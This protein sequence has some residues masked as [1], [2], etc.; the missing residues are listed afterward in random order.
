MAEG[1]QWIDPAGTATAL[2]DPASIFTEAGATGRLGVAITHTLDPLAGQPGALLRY[3]RVEPRKVGLPLVVRGATASEARARV[4]AL[5]YA[6]DPTRGIGRLRAT[7]PDGAQRELYAVYQDGLD[8]AE[9]T[10]P[11]VYRI[12]LTLIAPDPYWYAVDATQALYTLSGFITPL[13]HTPFFPLAIGGSTIN[14]TPT[15]LNP[16]DVDAWPVWIISGPGSSIALQNLTTGQS[17]LLSYSLSASDTVTIDTRPD[18]KSVTNSAGANLYRYLTA[19]SVL[20]ALVPGNNALRLSLAEA[21]TQ[22]T[23]RLTYTP[24]WIAP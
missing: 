12:P 1:L 2:D 7:A 24:R 8:Q 9:E 19:G 3:S 5:A 20:W 22:T 15:V 17:L 6:L 14:I 11:G 16:G 10:I 4:R 21:T 13:L 23:I 18:A